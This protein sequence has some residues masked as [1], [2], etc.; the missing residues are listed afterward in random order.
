MMCR[1]VGEG[2]GGVR[3]GRDRRSSIVRLVRV[4][5]TGIRESNGVVVSTVLPNSGKVCFSRM[6]DR[7]G[8]AGVNAGSFQSGRGEVVDES[9]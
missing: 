1:V 9:E 7:E 3:F 8:E 2:G 6:K 5:T 4:G